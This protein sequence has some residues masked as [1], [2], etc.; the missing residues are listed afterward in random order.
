MRGEYLDIFGPMRGLQS[1]P[2]PGC[3]VSL[4]CQ[5]TH[6]RP[7]VSHYLWDLGEPDL[8]ASQDYSNVSYYG[9][10]SLCTAAQPCRSHIV[11]EI[12]F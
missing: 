4:V 12:D 7:E 1:L 5:S 2:R 3:S 10:D 9:R 6:T 11:S 8:W